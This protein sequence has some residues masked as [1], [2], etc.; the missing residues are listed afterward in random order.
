MQITVSRTIS[1]NPYLECIRLAHG[2]REVRGRQWITELGIKRENPNSEIECSVLL[3]TEEISTR[4]EGK[5][6]PTVPFLVHNLIE[7]CPQSA[8]TVGLSTLSLDSNSDTEAFGYS[9][10]R[11]SRKHPLVLVSPTTTNGYLI[12]IKIV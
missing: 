11:P 10:D 8:K 6:Q 3:K 1:D 2:D 9:I 5:I 4:V 12:N 7:K